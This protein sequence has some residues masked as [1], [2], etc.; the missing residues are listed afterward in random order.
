MNKDKRW[1]YESLFSNTRSSNTKQKIDMKNEVMW[2]E[3][4]GVD[5]S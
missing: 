4:M 2:D 5:P 1:W 3:E